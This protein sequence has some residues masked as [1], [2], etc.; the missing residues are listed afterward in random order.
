MT[1]TSKQWLV[2]SLLASI[3]ALLL[4]FAW[5]AQP[6]PNIHLLILPLLL[7][8]TLGLASTKLD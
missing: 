4:T 3:W 7:V 2:W 6:Q 5:L 1:Y 8:L